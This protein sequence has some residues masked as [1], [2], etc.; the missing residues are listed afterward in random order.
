MGLTRIKSFLWKDF[1]GDTKKVF[2]TGA[3]GFV[4]SY[5]LDALINKKE[6]EIAVLVRPDSNIWRIKNYINKIHIIYGELQNVTSFRDDFINFN[7]DIVVNSAWLGVD[8][9][10]RNSVRQLSN[11]ECITN[12]IKI[13]VLCNIELFVGLG[14][15]AEY[16]VS[17]GVTSELSD[18]LPTTLYGST[19][20]SSYHNARILLHLAGIRFVW[21][22]V[23]DPYGPKDNDSWLIPYLINTSLTSTTITTTKAEQ[24]WD[25]LYIEDLASAIMELISNSNSHGI[26]NIG[27]GKHIKLKD[28]IEYIV[29]ECG[30]NNNIDYGA[31]P[32]R[33]DQVMHLEADIS[34]IYQEIGWEPKV[35]IYSGLSKTI[36]WYK[37]KLFQNNAL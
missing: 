23:Y 5:I 24:V 6:Y 37:S 9:G 16:G 7:P 32:Y 31:I 34:K 19:K 21:G 3:T 26:Y 2:L 4:G 1:M 35:N 28:V 11:I 25:F 10:S 8:S 29:K 15:Q 20:L 13:C 36:S 33:E 22:R 12:L 27:S 30:K 18:T 14:S 17:S